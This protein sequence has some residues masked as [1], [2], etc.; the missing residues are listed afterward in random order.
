M[1]TIETV[2]DGEPSG[3]PLLAPRKAVGDVTPG[4]ELGTYTFKMP[5]APVTVNAV[6]S[7]KIVTGIVDLNAAQVKAGQRYNLQGQ[8]VGKDYKG[9]VIENGRKIIVR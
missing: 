4:D 2:D 3:A 6:F 7:E 9:N 5:A 8:P 1:L